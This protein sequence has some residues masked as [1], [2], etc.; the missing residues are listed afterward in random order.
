VQKHVLSLFG[1]SAP[2][3]S[4]LFLFLAFLHRAEVE[5]FSFWPFCT[6]QKQAKM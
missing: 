3:R 1:L 5:F 2:R 6:A 4:V